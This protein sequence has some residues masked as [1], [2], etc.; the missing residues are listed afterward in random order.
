MI[1]KYG[2]DEIQLTQKFE[3]IANERDKLLSGIT[4]LAYTKSHTRIPTGESLINE[5][6]VSQTNLIN[7]S[8]QNNENGLKSFLKNHKRLL[9]IL[10]SV[11]ILLIIAVIIIVIKL[12]KSG[13]SDL[14]DLSDYPLKTDD[15]SDKPSDVPI[16]TDDPSDKPSD[17][18]IKTENIRTDFTSYISILTE[19]ESHISTI[20]PINE[21]KKECL[22]GYFI[23]DD[24]TS[25]DC[26][27]CS[28]ERCAK[29]K[30][31]YEYNECI[32]CGYHIGIYNGSK[33]SKCNNTCIVGY[34]LANNTCR[35]DFFIN[36][37]FQA[38][39]GATIDL[40]SSGFTSY[41]TQMYIDGKKIDTIT[42]K[43]QFESSGNHIVYLKI[44]KAG[45]SITSLQRSLFY[46]NEHLISVAFTDFDEYIPNVS[47]E[48]IFY[49]CK[50]LIS[51]DLSKIKI[52]RNIMN[53][54][55]NG[56]EKLKYVNLNFKS[57]ITAEMQTI[58]HMFQ[59]CISLTSVDLSKIN[60]SQIS[61]FEE[62]FYGCTSLETINLTNF[63]ISH[64]SNINIDSMF[65]NC[66]SLKSLDLSSFKPKQLYSMSKTFYNCY[67]LTSIN[68][69]KLYSNLVKDMSYLFY[70]CTSL[71]FLNLSDMLTE[72]IRD[73]RG[74]FQNCKS[75]TSIQFS[76]NFDTTQI[77]DIMMGHLFYNCH[78]LKK[79]DFPSN[80]IIRN[81]NLTYLFANCYSL[82]SIDMTHLEFSRV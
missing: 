73:M 2:N 48:F 9:I 1:F 18:P 22:E 27:K 14:E 37:T 79:I 61:H 12:K 4:L 16:K 70:N 49:G 34:K 52:K 28:L 20:D 25:D 81:N 46:N 41:V 30:G 57:V 66:T 64:K 13:E 40:F 78:S 31:T 33:I 72:K 29:C 47:F 54:M 35:P 43:Y 58:Q 6:N 10:S 23:P 11:L 26:V 77:S 15:P 45:D 63:E 17:V 82:T 76:E 5:T 62:V 69:E 68:L 71:K 39:R 8:P 75:L 59:N 32:D 19:K 42:Q 80:F 21:E 3:D 24:A 38:N 65:Y 74:M 53:S 56:C 7:D 60:V 55:F 51:A 44:S 36:A 50:N 67:S